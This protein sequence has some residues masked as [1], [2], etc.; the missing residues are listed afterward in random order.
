[1]TTLI[2]VVLI[3]IA[4]AVLRSAATARIGNP[5]TQLH[6]G[7][8]AAALDHLRFGTVSK[9]PPSRGRFGRGYVKYA[10]CVAELQKAAHKTALKDAR[11]LLNEQQAAY[12]AAGTPASLHAMNGPLGSTPTL[13]ESI[14]RQINLDGGVAWPDWVYTEVSN[15]GYEPINKAAA[16]KDNQQRIN[17][18]LTDAAI[19]PTRRWLRYESPAPTNDNAHKIVGMVQASTVALLRRHATLVMTA[20]G[21]APTPP[22]TSVADYGEALER[23]AA[24]FRVYGFFDATAVTGD[25]IIDIV[26][27]GLLV[28]VGRPAPG[29]RLS[30]HDLNPLLAAATNMDRLGAL[31][32]YDTADIDDT[33]IEYADEHAIALFTLSTL[34]QMTPRNRSAHALASRQAGNERVPWPHATAHQQ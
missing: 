23:V 32:L 33:V 26:A 22:S 28:S 25:Q 16:D 27:D 4:S 29:Y 31:V 8:Q 5:N 6:Q 19:S 7:A 34:G 9:K 15:L 21:Q 10:E 13:P 24:W 1:M 3:G 14:I 20:R 12:T 11:R 17:R 2:I 18:L 30:P